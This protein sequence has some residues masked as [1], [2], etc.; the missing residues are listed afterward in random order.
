MSGVQPLPLRRSTRQR[1]AGADAEEGRGSPR[2]SFGSASR[3]SL[4]YTRTGTGRV[5]AGLGLCL[6]FDVCYLLYSP[7]TGG[8]RR[9]KQIQRWG[10]NGELR[11]GSCGHRS[12]PTQGFT[13]E[14]HVLPSLLAR[15]DGPFVPGPRA[16]GSALGWVWY[17]VT[18]SVTPVQTERDGEAGCVQVERA[19]SAG[20]P[21]HPVG[22][23]QC[24]SAPPS[25]CSCCC[26]C[27]FVL[28]VSVLPA[29][30][31]WARCGGWE[32]VEV[33]WPGGSKKSVLVVVSNASA[34]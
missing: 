1:E 15:G 32:I 23:R 11:T 3:C 14:T 29:P 6:A 17:P 26:C 13:Y 2:S 8:L 31:G 12:G 10:K 7:C 34:A 16:P 4:C 25:A 19:L 27:C 9:A 21:L 5:R 24:R 18:F 30:I 28:V 22:R 20:S 33:Q